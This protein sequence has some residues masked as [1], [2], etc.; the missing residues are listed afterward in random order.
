MKVLNISSRTWHRIKAAKSELSKPLDVDQSSRLWS[1]AEILAKAQ[2][3]LGT[4]AEAEQ[5]LS[6]PAMGLDSRRPIELMATPQ[7]ADLVKTLLAQ[8]E[9]GVYA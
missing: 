1:M 3:V 9:F 7:G 5:W 4:R 6:Q 8:M 2:E